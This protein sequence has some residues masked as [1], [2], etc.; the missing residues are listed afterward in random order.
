MKYEI[1]SKGL[2]P[3]RRQTKKKENKTL[4]DI[5]MPQPIL[6]Q[7]KATISTNMQTEIKNH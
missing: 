5:Q 1:Y 3:E 4:N 7:L 2:S 6:P